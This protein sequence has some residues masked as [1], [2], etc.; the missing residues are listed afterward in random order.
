MKENQD[1][2]YSFPKVLSVQEAENLFAKNIDSHIYIKRFNPLNYDMPFILGASALLLT[3]AV[4]FIY[5]T[6]Y[7]LMNTNAALLIFLGFIAFPVG[8]Y[9]GLKTP[10]FKKEI[11]NKNEFCKK[12]FVDNNTS[13]GQEYCKKSLEFLKNYPEYQY[14]FD[15]VIAQERKILIDEVDFLIQDAENYKSYC[16][17]QK[18]YQKN[19]KQGELITS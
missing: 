8:F 18:I 14:Y 19:V 12:I 4:V 13:V 3:F 11:E 6:H 17:C 1:I 15:S 9:V 2:G 7:H 5:L 16:N 10:S